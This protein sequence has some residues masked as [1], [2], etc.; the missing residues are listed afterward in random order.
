MSRRAVTR[1]LVMLEY[2]PGNPDNG[3]VFDLTALAGEMVMKAN[4]SATIGLDVHATKTFSRDADAP[5][6]S[7]D[8]SW[9]GNAGEFVHGGTHPEDVVNSALPD[10]ERVKSIKNRARNLRKKADRLD[11]DAMVAKLEQVASVRAQFP[12]ARVTAAPLA[13]V[14]ALEGATK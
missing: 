10:G 14:R 13:D 12:I 9:N 1:V 4:Y 3:E 2:E 7:L 11:G 5:A 6:F 8:I